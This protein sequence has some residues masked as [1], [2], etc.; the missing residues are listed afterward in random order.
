MIQSQQIPKEFLMISRRLAQSKRPV[1][2][3]GSRGAS[4]AEQAYQLTLDQILQ[5]SLPIGSTVSRRH[6]AERFGMSLVPVAEALQRLENEGLVESRPR[7]G[8]RV[9]VPTAEDV[10]GSFEVREALECQAAR[11]CADRA[12]FQE[13]LE[14]E[15]S[16]ENLDTLFARAPAEKTIDG[17]GFAVEKYHVEFHMQIADYAH[18]RAL[19]DAI[20]KSHVLVLNWLYDVASKR[21]TLP[22]HFH[23]SLTKIIVGGNV[24][25]AERAMR[26]HVRH[27]LEE[28]Q[29]TVAMSS[30]GLWRAKRPT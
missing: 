11:L 6:L 20:E 19:R 22:P 9:R 15:R 2:K 1:R 23:A 3:T 30:G 24:D 16:A 10:R 25:Q 8:T 4:L 28:V 12:S 14:L 18:S 29:R 17:F 26:E 7:A 13:R 27:G 21:R 5:G